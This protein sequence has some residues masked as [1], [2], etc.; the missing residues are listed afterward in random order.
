MKGRA[1]EI[2]P[3]GNIVWEYVNILED[4]IAGMID[5]VQRLPDLYTEEYFDQITTKCGIE[6]KD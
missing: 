5:E 2:D 4:G 6:E 3:Q 1:F